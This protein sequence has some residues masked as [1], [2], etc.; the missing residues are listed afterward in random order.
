MNKLKIIV[1]TFLVV[2]SFVCAAQTELEKSIELWKNQ[3]DYIEFLNNNDVS[4][5]FLYEDASYLGIFGVNN[6]KINMR[7]DK[8]SKVSDEKYSVIGKSRLKGKIVGF[9]G[10]INIERVEF[11]NFDIDSKELWLILVGTYKFL[12]DDKNGFFEGSYRKYLIY[13]WKDNTI[14]YADSHME[15]SVLEGYAGKWG[16]LVSGEVYSC[17][18]GFNRYSEELGGDFDNRG[19]EPLMNSK[20]KKQGWSSHFV[21]EHIGSYGNVDRNDKWWIEK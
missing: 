18:F 17:H 8:V 15:L 7:F 10:E 2:F 19:G 6:H 5:A 4:S 21:N 14:T 12:E 1:L 16:S 11:N 3:L 9:T 20:Y 13:S